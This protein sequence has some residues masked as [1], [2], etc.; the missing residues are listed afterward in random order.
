MIYRKQLADFPVVMVFYVFPVL[1]IIAWMTGGNINYDYFW[2]AYWGIVIIA[3]LIAIIRGNFKV[4]E[5][6]LKVL[7]IVTFLIFLKYVIPHLDKNVAL[8][9]A[10][11]DGKWYVYLTI[12]IL[13]IAIWGY[14]SIDKTWKAGRFFCCV[15]IFKALSLFLSGHI[16]RDGVLMESNY[17]GFMI[18]IVYSLRNL[19]TKRGKYDDLLF[20]AATFLTLSRTG[21]SCLFALWLYKAIRKNIFLLI[22]IVPICLGIAV[23]GIMIRGEDSVGH[24]DR[25]VYWQQAILYFQTT[26]IYSVLF[27]HTPG[28]PMNV[29]ILPEFAWDV[30][31]FED[32][33]HLRGVFPFMFHSV[34]LR[35]AI[36][37]GIPAIILVVLWFVRKF[38]RTNM[39]EIRLLIILILIQSFSLSTMTLP[40]MSLLLFMMFMTVLRIEKIKPKKY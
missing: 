37:W 22:P 21:I 40:N 1:S 3:S 5:S 11:M 28:I 17:D 7:G 39:E 35:I 23:V 31:N 27:G 26:D 16:S 34:Y 25:F 29:F 6:H 38:F 2:G 36:T 8:T 10:I 4:Y 32:M 18:L 13:S 9:A 30:A 24:L 19:V 14:P 33:R 15:Y 20:I 12:A